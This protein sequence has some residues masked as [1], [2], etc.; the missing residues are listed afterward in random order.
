MNIAAFFSYIFL[1]AFTPGPNNMMAMSNAARG[2]FRRGAVFC[3]GVMLGCLLCMSLCGVFTATLSQSIPRIMPV[4]KWVGAGYILFLAVSVFWDKEHKGGPLRHFKP[5]SILTGV[6]M[7][8]LNIKGILYGVTAFSVFILP[9]S[10]SLPLLAL[11]VV[12]LSLMA[13]FG[14]LCWAAF[15]AFFQR[16]FE[17]HKRLMNG[18]I[19]LLLVGCAV[20]SVL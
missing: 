13:F 7:Q 4:M 18:I 6:L 1:A 15:G 19:A 5:D 3:I 16:F 12:I 2:G 17:K 11:V 9:H 20:M 8:F 10:R 14:T